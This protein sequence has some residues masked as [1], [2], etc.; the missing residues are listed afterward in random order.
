MKRD[1]YPQLIAWKNA[2]HRKPL[3]LKGARQ[4]G[5]TYLL[6]QFGQAE[7]RRLHYYNFEKTPQ[8]REFFLKNL[9]PIRIIE[10]LS[11]YAKTMITPATDLIIFDEVQACNG[12]LTSLKYFQEERPEYHIAAAG[13]LLGI[14]LSTPGSFPVGKVNLLE[15]HPMTFFEF[16]DAT[17]ETGL[18]MLIEKKEA[19]EPFEVPF[20]EELIRLL[21]IYYY[22]GG[23]PEAVR[24]YVDSRDMTHV[25]KVHDEILTTYE[26][27]FAKHAPV[28]DI[29]RLTEV[30]KSIPLH[31][32][33][34]NKKFVFAAIR[35]SARARDYDSALQWLDD[36]GLVQRAFA[37]SHV[38]MPIAGFIDR[39][40][41]KVYALDTGLLSAMAGIDSTALT[42]GDELFRTYHG[43]FVEN[44]VAQQL[45]ASAKVPELVYWRSEGQKAEVDFI[46]VIDGKALP[47]E[48]KAGIN[49]KSKSLQ[50]YRSRFT[51]WLLLRSTLL[52][53]R[54][55]GGILNVPL[56][57]V[58]D[59]ERLIRIAGTTR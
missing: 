24:S 5:K 29:P 55:D 46:R 13:S 7:Y 45:L 31:L 54:L 10:S 33:H 30:W 3:I 37:I 58:G 19:I 34:E 21:R 6:K 9:D 53:L 41:F 17:G 28:H 38:E 44:Y 15:L 2:P 40:I 50:S 59:L 35:K 27:D 42:R 20:H 18:R 43:A 16:L 4:T 26:L 1:I 14:K 32:S 51:P 52:N 39:D 49:P 22:V 25:A 48:V 47:L 57:A 11:L 12:A 23:M 36:A 56:Y 8:I